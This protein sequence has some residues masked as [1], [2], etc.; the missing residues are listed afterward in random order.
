MNIKK[1]EKTVEILEEH[2]SAGK[3]RKIIKDKQTGEVIKEYWEEDRNK[4][5]GRPTGRSAYF[6][7]LYKTN[8]QD[9]VFERRMTPYEAGIFS[10]LIALVGWQTPYIVHPDTGENLNE[11]E[12]AEFLGVSRSQLHD[13][14][15]SLVDK[16]FV[17]KVNKGNG[18]PNNYMLN[19][20]IVFNGK[21]IKDLNDH[22]VFIKDCSY[23]PKI[24]IKYR[25]VLD[26]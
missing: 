4:P 11:S 18:R 9:I 5:S 17:A 14:I 20:N 23:K 13:T 8:W 3:R 10:F 6:F 16:G 21:T 15:Q 25:Q 19:T 26:K 24:E 2:I 1:T 7:K 12:I 22:F